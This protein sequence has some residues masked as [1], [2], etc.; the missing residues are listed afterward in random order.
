MF[1]SLLISTS[2]P[3]VSV[4]LYAEANAT[5]QFF[6]SNYKS[7]RYLMLSFLTSRCILRVLVFIRL[8]SFLLILT[9]F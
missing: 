7:H 8:P 2:M 9:D 1:L 5:S 6:S 3:I 4:Y